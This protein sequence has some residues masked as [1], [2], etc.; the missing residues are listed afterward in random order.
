MSNDDRS[1]STTSSSV[2]EVDSIENITGQI[3]AE[4]ID[5]SFEAEGTIKPITGNINETN[6]KIKISQESTRSILAYILF[7]I[8]SIT[9]FL[10]LSILIFTD[11]IKPESRKEIIILILTSQSTIIGSA[12]GFYFAKEK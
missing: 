7:S 10:V 8:Y 4:L 9:I 12:L 6:A 2:D 5:S 3:E 11:K 1:S